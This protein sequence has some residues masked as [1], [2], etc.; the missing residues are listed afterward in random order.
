MS[1]KINPTLDRVVVKKAD[2][3]MVQKSSIILTNK[4]KN[5]INKFMYEVIAVG[6]GGIIDGIQVDMIVK[7]GDYVL[8]PEFI[9]SEINIDNEDYRIVKQSEILAI[10]EE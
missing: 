10:C 6:P 8:I 7:P 1:I 9:G 2:A 4:V 5:D 3:E